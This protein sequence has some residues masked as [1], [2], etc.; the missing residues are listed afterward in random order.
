M[1]NNSETIHEI[2]NSILQRCNA[3][4]QQNVMNP[5]ICR[6]YCDV[7]GGR[8]NFSEHTVFWLT[9]YDPRSSRPL[10][11]AGNNVAYYKNSKIGEILIR[12]LYGKHKFDHKF[13]FPGGGFRMNKVELDIKNRAIFDSSYG[14]V[15]GL[16][17]NTGDKKTTCYQT[18]EQLLQDRDNLQQQLEKERAQ[19]KIDAHIEEK[20]K[21]AT[22]NAEKKAAEAEEARKKAEIEA[23]ETNRIKAERLA[24][25]ARKAEEIAHQ[26]EEEKQRKAE[27]TKLRIERIEKLEKHVETANNYVIMAHR[28]VR[29]DMSLRSQHILDPMQEEI[30]RSHIFDGTPIV[31]EGGPGT[32]KTTTMIQRIKFLIS[33]QALAD[34]ETPLTQAQID[35]LT[36][37]RTISNNWIFFHQPIYFLIFLEEIWSTKNYKLVKVTRLQFRTLMA[38]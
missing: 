24:E 1:E 38:S 12:N 11:N 15:T 37:P 32:G 22:E 2:G 3:E 35:Q 8:V 10:S 30:K 6:A 9:N 7:D 29:S 18:L 31:I 33:P 16:S 34:Y 23:K 27:E 5:A 19:A 26:L 4:R 17:I 20:S 21:T 36:N 25:E 28:Q 13:A 14:S